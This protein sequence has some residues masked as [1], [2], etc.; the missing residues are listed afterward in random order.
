MVPFGGNYNITEDG[1]VVEDIHVTGGIYISANNVTVRNFKVTANAWYGVSIAGGLSGIVLEDGEVSGAITSCII[2]VGFTGRRLYL[3]DC[4]DG[5]KAKGS[6]GPTLVEYSFIEK[7][8]PGDGAHG[9][10]V[11]TTGAGNDITFRYNNI[12]MPW[13]GTGP[14]NPASPNCPDPEVYSHNATFIIGCSSGPSC[15]ITNYLIDNNW[16]NGGGWTIYC[17]VRN[18]I[19]GVTV[20]NNKFGRDTGWGLFGDQCAEVSG[21]TWEDTG[22]PAP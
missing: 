17:S 3:H 15:P 4:D 14:S 10:G 22:L 18:T 19:Q 6:G 2:G 12:Y 9:D 7:M 16:L 5:I 11:Q 1:T 13:C 8:G 21:N 20:T